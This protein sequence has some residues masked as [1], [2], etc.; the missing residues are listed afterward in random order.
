MVYLDLDQILI[1]L[2][3]IWLLIWAGGLLVLTMMFQ[4]RCNGD[5]GVNVLIF[6]RSNFLSLFFCFDYKKAFAL[7]EGEIRTWI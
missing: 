2:M 1:E 3:V 7:E 6:I 5:L 4:K